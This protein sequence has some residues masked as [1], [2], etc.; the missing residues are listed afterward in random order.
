MEG[1]QIGNL[2]KLPFSSSQYDFGIRLPPPNL[3]ENTREVLAEAG[4]DT[5][6]I[7]ALLAAKVVMQGEGR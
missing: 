2:P 5:G 1:G 7:D 3:G 4:L 6:Q